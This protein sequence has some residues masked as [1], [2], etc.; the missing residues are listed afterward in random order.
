L[1]YETDDWLF[2]V[3]PDIN[4]LPD[5]AGGRIP[6]SDPASALRVIQDKIIPYD[7]NPDLSDWKNRICFVADDFYRGPGTIDCIDHIGATLDLDKTYTPASID[8]TQVF[9]YKYAY[10][11]GGTK[12][13][14]ASDL[15]QRIQDGALTVNY[16][17]HGSPFKWAD[18]SVLLN[19]DADNFSNQQR[20]NLPVAASWDVSKFSDPSIPSLGERMLLHGGGGSIA[21]VAATEIGFPSANTALNNH[22]Y[23]NLF[24]RTGDEPGFPTPLGIAL[25]AAK[26]FTPSENS[27]RY[28]LLG[29]PATVLAA[30]RL[31]ADLQLFDASGSPLTQVAGERTGEARGTVLDTPVDPWPRPSDG[32]ATMLIEDAAP[33]DTVVYP[34]CFLPRPYYDPRAPMFRGD[35][36]VKNGQFKATFVVPGDAKLGQYGRVRAYL[37]GSVG[38][39]PP[40]SD[41]IGAIDVP[42]VAGTLPGGDDTGPTITLS[43]PGGAFDVRPG[44]TLR[45]DISDPSGVLITGHNPANSIFVTLDGNTNNRTDITSTFR[46]SA[47]SYQEGT[48]FFDLP[49]DI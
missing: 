18:E 31:W 30:P 23:G 45:A 20:L 10:G 49:N 16:I 8:R 1:P 4:V 29:D 7:A 13:G 15:K 48:A 39:A 32:L 24:R 28:P 40:D 25:N 6:V 33:P 38:G 34:A 5:V 43:F 11:P 2:D 27:R 35:V 19:S 41:G 46:Y 26:R 22:L 44:T 3:D 14:A 47:N 9:L 17:G 12:P 42:V 37:H 21:V 36:T